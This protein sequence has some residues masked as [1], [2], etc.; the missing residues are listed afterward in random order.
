MTGLL[1][2]PHEARRSPV[3]QILNERLALAR[4]RFGVRPSSAAFERTE[5]SKAAEDGRTPRPGGYSQ[6]VLSKQPDGASPRSL[7]SFL[8]DPIP[9]AD[10]PRQAAHVCQYFGS[11]D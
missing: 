1:K 8:K 4:Q 7:L 5:P 10:L 3:V 6:G 2:K 11:P 9:S